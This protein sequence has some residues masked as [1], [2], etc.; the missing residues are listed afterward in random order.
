M[1]ALDR[2]FKRHMYPLRMWR[3]RLARESP[4]KVVIPN[5]REARVRNLLWLVE[6]NFCCED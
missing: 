2:M 1:R 5:A 6:E 3:G 4:Y